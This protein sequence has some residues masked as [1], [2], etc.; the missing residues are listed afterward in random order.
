MACEGR[1]A[2][3]ASSRFRT[4]A[5][6]RAGNTVWPTVPPARRARLPS[7]R[8]FGSKLYIEPGCAPGTRFCAQDR[9]SRLAPH[10][11][12]L[13]NLSFVSRSLNAVDAPFADYTQLRRFTPPPLSNGIAVLPQRPLGQV[14]PG[15]TTL[16]AHRFPHGARTVGGAPPEQCVEAYVS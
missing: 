9:G 14:E 8:R 3:L 1:S 11:S 15:S 6:W 12:L 2:C 5:L 7:R 4:N 13:S 10:T 16:P